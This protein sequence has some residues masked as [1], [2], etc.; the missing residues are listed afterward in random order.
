MSYNASI[1]ELS[2]KIAQLIAELK[3]FSTSLDIDISAVDWT[4]NEFDQTRAQDLISLMTRIDDLPEDPSI[5]QIINAIVGADYGGLFVAAYLGNQENGSKLDGMRNDLVAKLDLIH[6]A[7]Q[8]ARDRLITINQTLALH[9]VSL[10]TICSNTDT[11]VIRLNEVKTVLNSIDAV[12]QLSKLAIDAINVNL[13]SMSSILTSILAAVRFE[14][15]GASSNGMEGDDNECDWDLSYFFGTG[16]DRQINN[17]SIRLNLALD[18]RIIID[19]TAQ[20][21][22]QQTICK[23]GRV[24]R[25]P[26]TGGPYGTLNV[27]IPTGGCYIDRDVHWRLPSLTRW[28]HAQLVGNAVGTNFN[29]Q[30]ADNVLLVEKKVPIV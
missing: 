6:T 17:I 14:I 9:G 8:D 3:V 10:T 2:A 1:A 28:I 18:E 12:S 5:V 20:D 13:Q 15:V 22:N 21:A 16:T 4:K 29:N 27:A 19:F 26:S 25:E 11:T 23:L 7:V 30:H 24:L